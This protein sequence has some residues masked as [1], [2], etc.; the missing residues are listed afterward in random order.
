MSEASGYW[1]RYLLALL[2]LV[3]Q[4]QP[5]QL[6][7]ETAMTSSAVRLTSIEQQLLESKACR[8]RFNAGVEKIVAR[9]QTGSGIEE[10]YAEVLCQPHSRY[11]DNPIHH[12]VYCDKDKGEWQCVRSEQAMRLMHGKQPLVYFENNIDAKLAYEI[13]L[14]LEKGLYFQGE[15]MPDAQQSVCNIRRH[16]DREENET[17][18]VVIAKCGNKEIFVS[19]WCP[20]KECPRIIGTRSI[21]DLH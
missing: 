15:E 7:A 3:C 1:R 14:R 5:A 9:R 10:F 19:T 8:E 6:S 11:R 17:Q 13:A 12:I 20:Q 2:G 21:T 16:S 4:I 18:D